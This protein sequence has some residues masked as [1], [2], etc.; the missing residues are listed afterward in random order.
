MGKKRIGRYVFKL[1]QS[2]LR[3]PKTT[4]Q[5][6]IHAKRSLRLR[7]IVVFTATR[8][9]KTIVVSSMR[10]N[11]DETVKDAKKYVRSLVGKIKTAECRE[12]YYQKGRAHHCKKYG[13]SYSKTDDIRILRRECADDIKLA[14]KLGRTAAAIHGRRCN[15]MKKPHLRRRLGQQYM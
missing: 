1:A 6:L 10:I 2:S 13:R 5:K 15:L 12:A 3:L 7:A 11:G 9:G 14:Q 4:V 8:N